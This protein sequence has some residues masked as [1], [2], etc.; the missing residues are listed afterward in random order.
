MTCIAAIS[1]GG[2]VYMGGDSAGTSYYDL[3]VRADDKVFVLGPYV[4]GFAGS[5][6]M[7]QLVQYA[8]NFP[9]PR[10]RDDLSRFM[11]TR[12]VDAVRECLKAGGL[13]RKEH[14]E[15]SAD[16]NFLVGIRGRLFYV[17]SDY[18]VGEESGPY[19]A[20]GSGA[21]PALGAFFAQKKEMAPK[22]RVLQALA[23]AQ[24]FNAAVRAPFRVVVG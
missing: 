21:G 3:S 17:E 7:R 10:A 16:G 18:N 13:A 5:F 19:M 2:K 23:A 11:A 4:M 12:F 24:R 1:H 20:V 22:E 14:E 9:A 8:A 15:E 6:R